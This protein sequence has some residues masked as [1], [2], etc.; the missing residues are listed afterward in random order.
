ML[1]QSQ[2]P[3]SNPLAAYH[4]AAALEAELRERLE[5]AES[6]VVRF[7]REWLAAHDAMIRAECAAMQ[8]AEARAA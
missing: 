1:S 2:I 5:R 8:T 4:R 6:V 3:T 7:R